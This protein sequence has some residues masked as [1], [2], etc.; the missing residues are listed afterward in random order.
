MPPRREDTAYDRLTNRK[1]SVSRT[2]TPAVVR[3]HD[4][5]HRTLI[6]YRTETRRAR[7]HAG[8]PHGLQR[9]VNFG[10]R[11]SANAFGPSAASAE[12]KTRAPSAFSRTKPPSSSSARTAISFAVFT[13]S[14]P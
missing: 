9:P 4:S 2:R 12:A 11:F 8:P 7:E 3:T 5:A 13:A 10:G 1:E 6:R 14:G